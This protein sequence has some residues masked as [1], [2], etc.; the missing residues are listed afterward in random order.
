MK[1]KVEVKKYSITYYT[2]SFISFLSY[3]PE[4]QMYCT[5]FPLPGKFT[6]LKGNH[7]VG[8]FE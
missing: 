4:V 3:E 7:G 1:P 5:K 2:T 6:L 8:L